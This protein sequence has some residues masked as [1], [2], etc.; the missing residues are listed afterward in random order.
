MDK[1]GLRVNKDDGSY[2]KLN[3]VDG[4]KG[5]NPQ[6]EGIFWAGE[7]E[8]HMKKGSVDESITIGDLKFLASDEGGHKGVAVVS[9]V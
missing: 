7:N 8:F 6:N 9:L 1:D 5:F 2:V 3:A 4:L